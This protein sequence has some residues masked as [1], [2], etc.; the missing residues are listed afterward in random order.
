MHHRLWKDGKLLPHSSI[1]VNETDR[2]DS[3]YYHGRIG[4]KIG[5]A[6]A[7]C[8]NEQAEWSRVC[9]LMRKIGVGNNSTSGWL[10]ICSES[11]L[12][13]STSPVVPQSQI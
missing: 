4:D 2:E 7:W 13:L 12:G 3:N 11:R 6:R 9:V 8:D 1:A 5:D 10:G